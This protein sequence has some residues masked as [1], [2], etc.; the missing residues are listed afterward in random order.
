MQRHLSRGAHDA[1]H[2]LWASPLWLLIYY[3]LT[4][5]LVWTH[6]VG[7]MYVEPPDTATWDSSMAEVAWSC[8]YQMI[9]FCSFGLV[10]T[11]VNYLPE[12][13]VKDPLELAPH[14]I[15]PILAF[16]FRLYLEITVVSALVEA[17]F[18]SQMRPSVNRLLIRRIRDR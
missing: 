16:L 15:M 10:P 2:M 3:T 7:P 9:D 18:H 1:Q 14:S 5:T 13:H 17:L 6:A 12:G 4:Q 11:L 8:L